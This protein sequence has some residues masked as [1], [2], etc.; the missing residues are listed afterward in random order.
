V[1]AREN[2]GY[3]IHVVSPGAFTFNAP[4]VGW[5]WITNNEDNGLYVEA[6][7]KITLTKVNAFDNGRDNSGSPISSAN[8]ISLTSTNSLG[9]APIL[10]TEVSAKGNT[11][12]GIWIE[13]KGAVTANTLNLNNNTNYGLYVDQSNAVDST[14]PIMLNKTYADG[15]GYDGIYVYAKGSITGNGIAGTSNGDTGVNLINNVSGSTGTI[16]ILNS[17]GLNTAFLN[18]VG[19]NLQSN[20]AIAITG[21]ETVSNRNDGIVVRN[22]YAGTPAVTL[23]YVINRFN[24]WNGV[25]IDSNGVVTINNSWSTSNEFDGF[26]IYTHS[27]VFFNNSASIMNGWA[28]IFVDTNPAATLKLTNSTW[29]GNKRNGGYIGSNLEYNCLLSIF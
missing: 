15:N 29:F 18:D 23:T 6:G 12:T 19:F 9:M 16:T 22:N 25:Y 10:L 21:I 5:N 14:K 4:A 11:L 3:G 1:G 28:G 2:S 20:G 26:Q 8:G 27:N 7:G 24:S 13:T 17:F